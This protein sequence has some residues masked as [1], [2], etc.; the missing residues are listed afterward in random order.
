MSEKNDSTPASLISALAGLFPAVFAAEPWRVHKPLAIGISADLIAAGILTPQEVGIALRCY[1]GRRQYFVGL[2]G[3]GPRYDLHGNIAGEVSPRHVEDAKR[4]LAGLDAA[5]EAKALAAQAA[6]QQ[7]RRERRARRE[8]AGE[9]T[10]R[11][12]R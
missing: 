5:R 2:A 3:G 11:C 8:G 1:T 7:A 10:E 6:Q 12:R 9:H 4:R